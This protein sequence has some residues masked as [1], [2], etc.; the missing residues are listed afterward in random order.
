MRQ[1]IRGTLALAALGV[2]AGFMT[3]PTAQGGDQGLVDKKA[4]DIKGDFAINGKPGSLSD[5]KGKVVLV[6]FW[7]VWCGPCKAVFPHLTHLHDKYKDKGLVI[8][9]VTTYYKKYNFDKVGG[10]L[11]VAA[12]NLTEKE[13]HAM[14]QDFVDHYKLKHNILAVPQDAWKKA[15]QDY[16]IKGI[17]TAVLI[18]KEGVVKLV[19]V[20]SGD[21]NAK[22]IEEAIERLT[23]DKR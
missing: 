15:S 19:R 18:D 17:P 16:G 2:L 10:K 12:Q 3:Q 1:I 7:A 6:D 22:A 20:G 8:L 23:N 9:G 21:A 5:L 14:L 13:E 11:S 4:P